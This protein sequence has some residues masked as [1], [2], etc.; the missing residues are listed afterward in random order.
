MLALRVLNVRNNIKC[1]LRMSLLSGN[2]L[3][4]AKNVFNVRNNSK[5]KLEI[6]LLAGIISNVSSQWYYCRE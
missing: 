6:A 4:V 5:C 3:N 2:I 1:K